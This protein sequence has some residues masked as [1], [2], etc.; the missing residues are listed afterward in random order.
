MGLWKSCRRAGEII[1]ELG[2]VK[3][4]TRRPTE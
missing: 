1:E 3:D 2:V 4:F